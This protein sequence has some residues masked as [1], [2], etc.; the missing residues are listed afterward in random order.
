MPT[1]STGSFSQEFFACCLPYR[2]VPFTSVFNDVKIIT[3]H[4]LWKSRFFS[5]F[6]LLME[7]SGSGRPKN[8]RIR[9]TALHS[10][11]LIVL[12][13]AANRCSPRGLVFPI[14]TWS[15][16]VFF[17][18]YSQYEPLYH[19]HLRRSGFSF[20][21]MGRSNPSLLLAGIAPQSFWINYPQYPALLHLQLMWI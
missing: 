21:R 3:N 12:L 11:S 2:R 13:T 17:R 8:L 10:C 20:L 6:C 16:V 14:G 18:F 5:I 1:K 4:K 15:F 9:N 7:G 19:V